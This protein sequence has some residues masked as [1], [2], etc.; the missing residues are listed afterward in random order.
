MSHITDPPST[1]SRH[2]LARRLWGLPGRPVS[3]T[4]FYRYH[5]SSGNSRLWFFHVVFS[6][7]ALG[8]HATFGVVRRMVFC[9]LLWFASLGLPTGH[10]YSHRTLAF[11]V[12]PEVYIWVPPASIFIPRSLADFTFRH[13][14]SFHFSSISSPQCVSITGSFRTACFRHFAP[15]FLFWFPRDCTKG[16]DE[17]TYIKTNHHPLKPRL[18]HVYTM[19][20]PSF[21][22]RATIHPQTQLSACLC[23]FMRAFA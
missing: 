17:A 7:G 16:V 2:I 22:L 13:P 3:H 20:L 19:T 4:V 21:R 1:H 12:T 11:F 23:L 15:R 18:S 6:P 8:I 9:S 5:Y 10:G 14:T